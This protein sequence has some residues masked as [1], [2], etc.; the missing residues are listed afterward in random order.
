MSFVNTQF[1]LP[2]ISG[3]AGNV[4][5]MRTPGI[6]PTSLVK[7]GVL[8]ARRSLTIRRAT[9]PPK[10]IAFPMQRS[11][12]GFWSGTWKSLIGAAQGF[13]V[14]GPPGAV[15]GAVGGRVQDYQQGQANKAAAQQQAAA[16]SAGGLGPLAGIGT[17]T[18]VASVLGFSALIIVL[19]RGG[20]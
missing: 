7:R 3:P 17:G 14:G 8:P 15:V 12:S 10:V 5:M 20:R 4:V 11:M 18:I 1:A 19:A 6:C 9:R 2:S 13:L 16:G